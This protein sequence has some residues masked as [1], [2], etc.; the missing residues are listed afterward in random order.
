MGRNKNNPYYDATALSMR[1]MDEIL[2]DYNNPS[3]REKDPRTGKMQIT[4][5]ARKHGMSVLKVRRLLVSSHVLSNDKCRKIQ[6]LY[7]DGKSIEEICSFTGYGRATVISYLPYFRIIYKMEE[8]SPG[9]IRARRH[10]EKVKAEKG[11]VIVDVAFPKEIVPRWEVTNIIRA[12]PRGK[13]ILESQIEEILLALHGKFELKGLSYEII[14]YWPLP[15]VHI[16]LRRGGYAAPGEEDKLRAEG[17]DLEVVGDRFRVLDYKEHLVSNAEMLGY[18]GFIMR[19][20]VGER[21]S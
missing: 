8:S 16:V 1:L 20:P 13:L 4:K 2:Q 9:A 14:P 21:N 12:V 11:D 15:P 10:R 17:F 3:P 18:K 6:K 5:L 7:R 19:C